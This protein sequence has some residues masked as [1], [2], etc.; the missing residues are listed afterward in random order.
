MQEIDKM[1]FMKLNFNQF[2][3]YYNIGQQLLLND[4]VSTEQKRAF[5]ELIYGMT[6]MEKTVD[7]EKEYADLR[8]SLLNQIASLTPEM[9]RKSM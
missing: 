9:Q 2:V 1:Q 4:S 7:E 3:Q 6:I 8:L 5:L